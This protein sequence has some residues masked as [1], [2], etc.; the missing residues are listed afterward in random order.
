MRTLKDCHATFQAKINAI[1]ALSGKPADDIYGLWKG[2]AA[3]CSSYDQSPVVFEFCQWYSEQLGR[4]S[5]ELIE[6]ANA[7]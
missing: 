5:H 2:Y 1:A 7:A 6:A 3:T 4:P